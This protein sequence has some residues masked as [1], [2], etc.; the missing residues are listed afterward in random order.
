MN[1]QNHIPSFDDADPENLFLGSS[2]GLHSYED[3]IK[4]EKFF[5]QFLFDFD[6]NFDKPV[7]FLSSSTDTLIFAIAACWKLGIPFVPFD[8]KATA[9]ELEKQ[10]SRIKPGLIFVDKEHKSLL[11]HE[12]QI[13]IKQLDLSRSLKIEV[14]Q[15]FDARSYK[16]TTDPDR[17]FGYFF[18]SGTSG[19]PK[20]VPLKRRQMLFAAEASAANFKPRPNHFWLLCL[21][22]N[23]ISGISI[24]LR[25]I[26]YGSA[27]FRMNSFHP[28]MII[29]FLS[30]NKLFQAASLVP[31]MLKQ[32]LDKP[33][34]QIHKNFKAFLL[35]GG[36]IDPELIRRSNNKGVPLVPSYGMTESCAQIAANPILKPSGTHPPLSSV[37]KVFGPNEIQI[38]NER[39]ECLKANNSGLIWLKGPQIFDG[40]FGQDDET[41]F[42][43]KGWFNTGDYGYLNAHYHLFI[44][45]RRKDLI[46][47]GGENVS[48]YEVES[49]LEKISPITEAAVLGLPDKEWGQRVVAVVVAKTEQSI[50]VDKIQQEL[51]KRITSFKVPKQ[52]LQT[53]S[54]PKTRTGKIRR[55][56]LIK[57]FEQ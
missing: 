3:L 11:N 51:K 50:D 36:P 6:H 39:G 10:V 44:E 30:E 16:P 13:D 27:I 42:D 12:H 17:V 31:T 21:P 40:Y 38:R 7:G 55:D 22:L 49:E 14:E 56:E 54:L 48:P 34:F 43:E 33:D 41:Y 20:I 23:H 25:S 9:A 35:G 47:S 45:S 28:R 2:F 5:I 19:T 57:L 15:S 24:V 29:T 26:L 37:G 4:F 18:T 53:K 32:L 46:I 1:E 52:I 8:P